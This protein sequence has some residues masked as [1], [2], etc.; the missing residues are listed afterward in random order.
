[1]RKSRVKES[2]RNIYKKMFLVFKRKLPMVFFVVPAIE[3]MKQKWKV[4]LEKAHMVT[5]EFTIGDGMY[6]EGWRLMV[7]A[8]YGKER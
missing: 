6:Y 7:I 4:I 5:T 1:M 8:Y 2:H 3:G